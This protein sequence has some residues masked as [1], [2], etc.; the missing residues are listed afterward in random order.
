M[1]KSQYFSER[2]IACIGVISIDNFLNSISI[3]ARKYYYV[4]NK[5]VR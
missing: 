4:Q 2:M 5:I 1:K 3:K